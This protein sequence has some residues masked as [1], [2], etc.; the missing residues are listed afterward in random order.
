MKTLY[1]ITL[2]FKNSIV[3]GFFNESFVGKEQESSHTVM[4]GWQ[5]GAAHAQGENNLTFDIISTGIT[6]SKFITL[7]LHLY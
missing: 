6:A 2:N 1:C 5:K 3:F 4:A 7:S